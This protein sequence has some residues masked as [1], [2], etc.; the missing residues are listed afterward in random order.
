ME[1]DGCKRIKVA[2]QKIKHRVAGSIEVLT[3]KLLENWHCTSFQQF[4]SRA[5]I[6]FPEGVGSHFAR[7]T[8]ER[9]GVHCNKNRLV[10][11]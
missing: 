6:T 1:C 2:G 9:A 11:V 8:G 10:D 5:R 4:P 3:D 7:I